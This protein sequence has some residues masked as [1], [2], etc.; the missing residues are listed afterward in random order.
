MTEIFREIDEELRLEKLQRVWR[1]YGV[2]IIALIV[3][4][5]AGTAAYVVWKNYS[6]SQE[7][8]RGRAFAAALDQAAKA[9]DAAKRQAANER[10]SIPGL[11]SMEEGQLR[12][13]AH[14]A[15]T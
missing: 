9:D 6:E 14:Q 2:L 5:V 7:L 3:G 12:R 4:V 8:D 1:R 10:V 15:R 11:S 13:P